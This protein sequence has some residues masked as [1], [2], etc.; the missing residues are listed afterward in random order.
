[1]QFRDA[2]LIAP[3]EWKLTALLRGQAGTEGAM[4]APVA[5]GSRVVVLDGA[6][7]Q[8]ALTMDN[9]ALPFF[10]RWGPAAKPISDASFQTSV[11]QFQALGLRP[12]SPTDIRARWN[13][14]G[15]IALSWIRRT[16]IG[17]DSWEQADVPLG[18]DSEAYEIDIYNG[19]SVVRTL[20]VAAPAASYT[21]AQQTA[22]F[23]VQQYAVMA[24]IYQMSSTF[25]RGAGRNATLYY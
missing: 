2:T 19:A 17:G 3:G 16:R 9:R 10:Y 15:D 21:L 12:L 4:R 6:L 18:E 7:K 22:D 14:S 25:G 23:G 13:V 11:R 5:A 1:M 8:L 20:T 24:A